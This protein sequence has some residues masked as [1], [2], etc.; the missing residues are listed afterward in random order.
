MTAQETPLSGA[1]GTADPAAPLA[2]ARTTPA[3]R[4]LVVA[5]SLGS[6]IEHYDFFIYAFTAPIVFDTFFF[7]KMD[8]VASMVAVYATFAVG[9]VARPLGGMVFGHYGDKIG[10]KAMLMMT[11][12]LMGIASF[13]IGCLPSYDRLGLFAPIALVTLRFVQG[14]AFGGEYMNAVSL[15]LENAPS[16]R[17][18]FFASWVNASG[19]MGIIAASGLIAGL[20]ALYS[21]EEFV[22]WI[23][24]VPFLFSFVLVLIGT[25]IRAHVDE[26][27]LFRQ[28]KAESKVARMP[29][30]EVFAN[31]KLATLRGCLANMVHST[32][33]YMS[34]VFVLGYAVKT[35]GMAPSSVTSG[36]MLANI[37]EMFMVPIIAAYSD[38]FG[39]RPFLILGIV[40]AAIWYPIFF[41][42][43]ATREAWLLIGGLVVSIGVIHALMFAPEA[44]YTAELFP[45]SIRVSGS[46]LGKQLGIILGGGIAPLVGTALMGKTG[47]FTSVIIYFEVIAALALIAVVLAP[48][49]A[50]KALR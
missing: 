9:F 43:V 19:P 28:A 46:S 3:F 5:S 7:P 41:E 42:L 48:E 14:F 4:R 23:W 12:L 11:F 10:R 34:T 32:F 39:R 18:G 15:T 27:L 38:R 25:Y 21:R 1:T 31:W 17:R 20:G 49:N 26:S 47:S 2:S 45:T 6:A 22:N 44:A 35:L 29:L 8:S 40:L 13:L 24:R 33:Q 37:L 16:G 30:L 36:T 50:K